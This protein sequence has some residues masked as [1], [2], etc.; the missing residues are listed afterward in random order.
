LSFLQEIRAGGTPLTVTVVSDTPSVGRLATATDT[1]ASVTVVIPVQSSSVGGVAFDA[2]TA[3]VTV[4]S[5]FASGFVTTTAGGIRPV[6]VTAPA[7]TGGAVTVG[8]GLQE[9]SSVS[10][11]ASGHGGVDVVVK[12]TNPQ[13]AL[14]SPNVSTPGTDS[15]VV[16]VPDGSASFAYYVQGF[17][18][19]ADTVSFVYS[20]PLFV[21]DTTVQTVVQPQLDIAGLNQTTTTLT[22]NDA[23]TVRVGRGNGVNLSV[24]QEVRAGGTIKTVT[25]TSSGPTIGQLET[26]TITSGTVTVEIPV[27][28][29]SSPG[30][31]ALGGVAFD[32]VTAGVTTVSA[33]SPGFLTTTTGGV[34]DVT[35]STPALTVG[36]VTVGAGLQENTSASFGAPIPTQG[37]DTLII[38]S[39]NPQFALVAPNATTAGTDSIIILLSPGQTS[40]GY[41]VHGLEGQTG[42]VTISARIDGF[43]DG[44]N[45]TTV[46]QPALDVSGLIQTTTAGAADDPFVV[47][48]GR[49]TAS[50]LSALQEA[51]FGGPGFSATVTSSAPAFGQLV[52]TALTGGSVSVLIPAGASASAS[53]VA[54]GGVAFD[55]VSAGTTTVSAAIAGFVTTTGGVRVVTINP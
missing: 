13:V 31:V 36:A 17:E 54:A 55:A 43:T 50:S 14:V 4:V 44:S 52:T 51:R 48:I 6:T 8:A 18:G 22:P 5:A 11:G 30:S 29:S 39:S 41:Y 27:G 34:R 25:V 45:T 10:L 47:R 37:S 28:L 15:I 23:F 26:N 24:L 1:A 3:G 53:T 21:P 19:A 38:K 12:S 7:L 33:A 2:L 42:T 9:N 49:G 32:P 40:V 16:F 20:T 46:V 35:V